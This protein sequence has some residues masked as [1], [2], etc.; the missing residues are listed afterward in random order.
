M[1]HGYPH[2]V[3]SA[4]MVV[5]N[6]NKVTPT[7]AVRNLHEGF[8]RAV[9]AVHDIP[10]TRI[11]AMPR[12]S[13]SIGSHRRPSGL[14]LKQRPRLSTDSQARQIKIRGIGPSGRHLAMSMGRSGDDIN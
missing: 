13:T 6:V 5:S 8:E 14:S 1:Q 7:K 10:T 11:S 12:P 4:V 2:L 3:R 9:R